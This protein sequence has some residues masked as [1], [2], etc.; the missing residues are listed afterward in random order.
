MH[1]IDAWRTVKAVMLL[2]AAD[3][4]DPAERGI[5]IEGFRKIQETVEYDGDYPK[6]LESNYWKILSR[7]AKNAFGRQCHRCGSSDVRLDVHHKTYE[8]IGRE[9]Y[10]PDDLEVL[11]MVCHAKEHGLDAILAT[12]A[13][14]RKGV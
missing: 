9:L 13:A 1:L 8:H 11:C 12:Q 10:F 14:N 4:C 2:K 6:Y 3:E 7:A 5:V